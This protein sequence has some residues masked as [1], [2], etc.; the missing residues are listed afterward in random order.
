MD[1][2]DLAAFE[3]LAEHRRDSLVGLVHVGEAGVAA[4]RRQLHRVK[5]RRTVWLG[6]IAG[7]VV[8]PHFAVAEHADRLAVLHDVGD[9]HERR[10]PRPA[11]IAA[12]GGLAPQS[13]GV[14]LVVVD[15]PMRRRHRIGVQGEIREGQRQ[16]IIDFLL[17]IGN[18]RARED[19][20][21]DDVGQLRRAGVGHTL[22][23]EAEKRDCAGDLFDGGV[24]L[25][26]VSKPVKGNFHL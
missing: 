24:E 11:G 9:Q 22:D 7:V 2:Q 18:L 15:V 10:V 23:F 4:P 16:A 17:E 21:D 26:V 8:E 3:A 5:Q 20:A 19:F 25:D 14:H 12:V 1:L 13:A 6:V